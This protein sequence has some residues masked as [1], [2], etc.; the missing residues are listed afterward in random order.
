MG[1]YAE[2]PADVSRA[3]AAAARHATARTL[4]CELRASKLRAAGRAGAKGDGGAGGGSNARQ[5]VGGGGGGGGGGGVESLDL[6]TAA[7]A[8]AAASTGGGLAREEFL[9]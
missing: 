7:A 5:G 9:R 2:P 4:L 8:A 6:D 3:D 1:Y